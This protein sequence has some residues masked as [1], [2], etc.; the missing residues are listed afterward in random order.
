MELCIRVFVNWEY[1]DWAKLLPMAEFACNNSKNTGIG[2]MLFELNC[3]Y[4]PRVSFQKNVNSRTRFCS[5]NK[6]AEEE[7]ELIEVCCQNLLHAQKLQKRA[8][9]KKIKNCS[10]TLDK[11]VWLNSKYIK[12]M[13]NYKK[14]KSKFFRPFQILYTIEKQ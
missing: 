12:T 4:H 11:K 10:Y 3:V 9:D 6:L 14:L 1:D 7:K 13:R 2:H 5:T 8:Y